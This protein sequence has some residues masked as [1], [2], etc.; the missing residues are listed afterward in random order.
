MSPLVDVHAHFVTPWYVEAAV[1]AGH[2][3]PDGIPGWPRWSADEHLRMMDAQGIDQAVLSISSPGV[4]FGDARAAVELARRVN[5]FAAGVCAERPDRF[6]FFG[7]LPLPSTDEALIELARCLDELGASGITAETNAHGT[8]LTD[9]AA[10]PVLAELERRAAVLF[11]H[12]TSPPGGAATSLGLPRPM[13]EFLAESTRTI[14]GLIMGG[15]VT[16]ASELRLIVPHCGAYLPLLA[17]RLD[18]FVNALGLGSPDTSEVLANLWY[19]LAGTP[20]PTHANVLIEKAGT[21]KLL[22]GSDYCWTPAPAVEHHV[23]SL[24][25]SW[26]TTTHGP[27]RELVAANAAKLFG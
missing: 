4:F 22:Y 17:D 18:L 14:T 24:D 23:T 20:M 5:D 7:A 27:W 21:S 11:V 16:N 1:A 19:D 9:P 25:T 2:A 8:Y 6:R 15:K 13:H 26:Q 10:T 3:Q 12:P